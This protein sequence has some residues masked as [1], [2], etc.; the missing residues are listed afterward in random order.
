MR[1]GLR[2]CD[3]GKS[4]SGTKT[5][6]PSTRA[7]CCPGSLAVR[8]L[9]FRVV[10]HRQGAE[11]LFA[12][13]ARRWQGPYPQSMQANTAQLVTL[14][15][16][17]P[18]RL[19]AQAGRSC[20]CSLLREVPCCVYALSVFLPCDRCCLLFPPLV[21]ALRSPRARPGPAFIT[22]SLSGSG[23]RSGSSA[24]LKIETC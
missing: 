11:I 17:P 9:P 23:T 15:S 6:P 14:R 7:F 19:A 4:C 12:R 2:S 18:S 22:R 1:V 24:P 20:S 5:E 21:P 8:F 3:A 10:K 16:L 13:H